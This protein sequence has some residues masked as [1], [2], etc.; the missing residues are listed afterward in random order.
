MIGINLASRHLSFV[1][2][3]LFAH[4]AI[5]EGDY[6]IVPDP[7]L[8][9]GRARTQDTQEICAN[10]TKALRHWFRGAR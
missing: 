5:A 1:A 3:V 8:T 4:A 2:A 6:A 10:G 9:P 7:T